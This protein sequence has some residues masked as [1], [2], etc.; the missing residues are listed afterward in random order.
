MAAN[1]R[2]YGAPNMT[3]TSVIGLFPMVLGVIVGQ[4]AA[5]PQGV[6]RLVVQNGIIWR[7]PVQPRPPLRRIEWVERKGP[8]WSRRNGEIL[9]VPSR[10]WAVLSKP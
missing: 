4:P 6:T 8:G 2:A 3:L 1:H 5:V 7:V 9:P 10:V